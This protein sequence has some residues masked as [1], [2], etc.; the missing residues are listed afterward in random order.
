MRVNDQIAETASS[1]RELLFASLAVSRVSTRV[2][3]KA[4]NF[5]RAQGFWMWHADDGES[6]PVAGA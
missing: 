6:R 5:V 3:R 4:V 2:M 1:F